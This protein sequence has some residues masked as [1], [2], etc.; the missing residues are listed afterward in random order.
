MQLIPAFLSCEDPMPEFGN[1]FKDFVDDE[2]ANMDIQ[3]QRMS[4]AWHLNPEDL[5]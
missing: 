4:F 2:K 3:S 5:P 1:F